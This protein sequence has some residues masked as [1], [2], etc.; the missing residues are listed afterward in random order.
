VLTLLVF[1]KN[2]SHRTAIDQF[3]LVKFAKLALNKKVDFGCQFCVGVDVTR[4][5]PEHL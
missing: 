1:K 4:Y 3:G 5:I 2:L